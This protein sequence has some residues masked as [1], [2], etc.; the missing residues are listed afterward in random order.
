MAQYDNNLT[1]ILS[2]NDRKEEPNHPDYKGNCT[3]DGVEFWISGWVK[4]RKDG[5][6]SF[7]SLS[8]TPKEQRG[9]QR[10]ARPAPIQKDEFEF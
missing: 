1:G 6:G 3:I 4:Q 2:K 8:F 10:Q 7:L 9:Q 5:Q